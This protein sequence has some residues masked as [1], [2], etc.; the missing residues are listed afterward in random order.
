MMKHTK[1]ARKGNGVPAID[2]AQ[3]QANQLEKRAD[4]RP[5]QTLR[6]PKPA[7]TSAKSLRGHS[8][9]RV[10]GMFA[11]YRPLERELAG[12]VA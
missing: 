2:K 1:P 12:S 7:R 6:S 8:K 9:S 3:R 10:K 5:E 4:T 11:G